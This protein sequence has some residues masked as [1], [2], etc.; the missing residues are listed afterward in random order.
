M[1]CRRSPGGSPPGGCLVP[2]GCL[3]LGGSPLGGAWSG[4]GL[5]LWPSVVA[6]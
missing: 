6:F 3:L 5:L 1:P 4:G 2:G